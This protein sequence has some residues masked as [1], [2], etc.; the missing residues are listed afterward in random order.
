MPWEGFLE[1]YQKIT[2]FEKKREKIL[3]T[4]SAQKDKLR[5]QI[6][7][8]SPIRK[9]KEG[10]YLS[11]GAVDSS[12]DELFGDDWGRRLFAICISGIGFILNGFIHQEPQILMEECILE[13]EEDNDY[14]RILKGL[15]IA[16]EIYNAKTW[17]YD[18]DLILIDGSAKSSIIAIN[19]ALTS[20]YS[21]NSASGKKL[22][23]IYKDTLYALH[24]MLTLG[25]LVFIPKR[26]SEVLIANKIS[27]PINNDYAL[28][29]VILEKSEYIMIETQ[30]RDYNLPKIEGIS[31]EFLSNLF[32]SLN[33]LK[34]IYF[35]S[36]S[37]KII[38]IETYLPL[39]AD[40]LWEYFLLEGENIL[41]YLVDKSAKYYLMELKKYAHEINP[42][43]YRL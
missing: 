28:L 34:V 29:E 41:T 26:S 42:W 24:E 12:F 30:K 33:N 36:P 21:E 7:S 25:K 5:K 10:K 32:S 31:E 15:A 37:G 6:N 38:K 18:M 27:S 14:S 11:I 9:I 13:Y 35:K 20:K 16:Q 8:I 17:F 4:L 23:S 19:Q 40:T 22:K 2:D 43:K 1:S 3:E 39:F